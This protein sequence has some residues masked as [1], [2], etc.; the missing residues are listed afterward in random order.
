[1]KVSDIP[2]ILDLASAANERGEIFVPLFVGEAGIGKSSG[3]QQW[4]SAQDA[5][6]KKEGGF[7]FIDLRLAYYEGPDMVGAPYSFKDDDGVMRTGNSLPNFWPTKGR[8]LILFEEPNLGNSMIQNTM[9][10]ILTDRKVGPHYKL[11]PGWVLAGAMNPFTSKYDTNAMSAA[12][13]NRFQM[14]DIDFDW[15]TFLF[16]A[17]KN[18]WHKN[19]IQFLKSGMWVYKK[20]EQIAEEDKYVSPRTWDRMSAAEFAGASETEELR[21]LHKIVSESTLGPSIGRQY[22]TSCWDEAPVMADDLIRDKKTSL[23]KI[24][25]QCKAGS[26]SG[27]KL[28]I[29]IES[30]AAKYDGWYKDRKDKK[31]EMLPQAPDTIDEATLIDVLKLIP[32]DQAVNLMNSTLYKN[33]GGV[34]ITEFMTAFRTR[35]PDAIEYV[36]MF[37]KARSG[38]QS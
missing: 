12:L 33:L 3:T 38:K 15:K 4:V 8:G 9:M 27:D 17:E 32:G 23:K 19:V 20:P 16:Y 5:K 25:D 28:N 11:P 26:Y 1:M 34:S 21:G 10:Q 29:T 24:K 35:N 2:K 6:Y 36:K 14:F 37:V 31:G 13:L 22:W 18:N 7:G 30:I